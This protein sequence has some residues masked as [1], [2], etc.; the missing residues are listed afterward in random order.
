MVAY[1]TLRGFV[2][3]ETPLGFK[4]GFYLLCI[5]A[6]IEVV[7]VV[8]YLIQHVLKVVSLCLLGL[9]GVRLDDEQGVIIG[10]CNLHSFPCQQVVVY[11]SAPFGYH[12]GHTS[13]GHVIAVDDA[14]DGAVGV[15][16]CTTNIDNNNIAVVAL[17]VR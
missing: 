8:C 5:H 13:K 16:G 10:G 1:H 17:L 14:D 15:V 11:V 7:I 6:A 2:G 3:M 12:Y 9:Q 4:T